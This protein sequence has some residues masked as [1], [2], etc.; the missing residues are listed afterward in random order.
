MFRVFE[1]KGFTPLGSG[2]GVVRFRSL[3]VCCLV[4]SRATIGDLKARS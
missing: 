3:G 2:F 4:L 1:L